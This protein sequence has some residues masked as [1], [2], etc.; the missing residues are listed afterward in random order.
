MS[1]AMLISV[2]SSAIG[3]SLG[4]A[5]TLIAPAATLILF[6]IGRMGLNAYCAT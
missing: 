4:T 5:G 3:A 6:T 1:K 2:M